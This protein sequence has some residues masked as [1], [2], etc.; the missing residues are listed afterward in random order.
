[1]TV[2]RAL[3]GVN[4]V[5]HDTREAILKVARELNY[6]PNSNA[7]SLVKSSANIVGISFPTL[8]NDVF[9]DMFEGMKRTF[10]KA[11]FSTLVNTTNYENEGEAEWVSNLLSWRPAGIVLTGVDHDPSLRRILRSVDIPTLEIWDVT[12]DPIDMCVGINHVDAG[13][14]LGQMVIDKGYLR[15]AFVG[16]PLGRD[17]RADRRLK[18]VEMAF[19]QAQ[20]AEKVVHCI[21]EVSNQFALGY[22]AIIGLLR[23]RD[24]P[25][26]VFFSNDHMA[27][28]GICAAEHFGYSVPQDIG[29]V[30]FNALSLTEV[31]SRPLTTART[32][33]RQIGET[34]ARNMIAKIHGLTPQRVVT[35]P[36]KIETGDTTRPASPVSL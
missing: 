30:G 21:R 18:G 23:D 26:V 14:E 25:D 24:T 31:L 11:G 34:A 20:D 2:S 8:F 28:G 16:L 29:I 15:P 5:S 17:L 4:G 6:V 22:N 19:E 3:R 13:F 35:L 9:A 33:R 10:E 27:F 12:E 36:V 32:P 7:R 1:M